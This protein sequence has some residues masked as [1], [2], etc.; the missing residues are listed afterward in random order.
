MTGSGISVTRLLGLILVPA[1]IVGLMLWGLWNPTERLGTVRA[2]VVNLDEPVDIDGQLTPLGRV[3]AAELIGNDT[4]ENF[5]W[6]L[7]DEADAARGLDSGAYITVGT[8][9]ETF[10]EAATSL[11]AGPATAEQAR[12]HIATSERAMLLDAALATAVTETA[13]RLINE[14]LGSAV[15]TNIAMGMS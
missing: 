3:L 7:T 11:G 1:V 4:E 14:Q 10:S 13:T 8:I 2:A 9:P 5:E 15:I 12:I 6:I